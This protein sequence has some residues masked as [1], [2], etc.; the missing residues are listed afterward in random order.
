M[1][2]KARKSRSGFH[3]AAVS[4]S[5]HGGK[6]SLATSRERSKEPKED[7][8]EKVKLQYGS[9][10]Q[11]IRSDSIISNAFDKARKKASN[12]EVWEK[13]VLMSERMIADPSVQT[14]GMDY[15]A[16]IGSIQQDNVLLSEL[17]SMSVMQ[18]RQS[19]YIG[20]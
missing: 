11:L 15:G 20:E 19:N 12:Y 14:V 6:G 4:Y 10:K 16:H 2:S 9:R 1:E 3:V 5:G 18:P 17:R 13:P 8:D 7:F